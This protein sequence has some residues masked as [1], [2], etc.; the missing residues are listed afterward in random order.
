MR[1]K[2]T[3]LLVDDNRLL[4]DALTAMLQRVA[5][6]TIAAKVGDSVAAIR[7]AQTLRPDV[8]LVD[9]GVGHD[10]PRLVAGLKATAPTTKVVVLGLSQARENVLELI[11]AGASGF[12]LKKATPGDLVRTV[13]AVARGECL[14][15]PSLAGVVF[16]Q[17]VAPAA[18]GRGMTPDRHG[19]TPREREVIALI[20]EGLSNKQ[21]GERLHIAAYTVKSHVHNVLRKLT[22]RSRFQINLRAQSASSL[23]HAYRST[24]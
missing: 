18:P 6:F 16:A 4:R 20:G 14:L 3:L 11:R 13:R 5:D 12:V 8:T 19:L 24:A 7:A 10:S 9:A 15:P 1:R 17:L 21:I 23:T 2:T 22:L